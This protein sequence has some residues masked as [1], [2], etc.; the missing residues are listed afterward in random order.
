[1]CGNLYVGRSVRVVGEGRLLFTT[2]V[3]EHAAAFADSDFDGR[4]S[5]PEAVR[6]RSQFQGPP[7]GGG[8]VYFGL[9]G[10]TA[11]VHLGAGVVVVG[12]LHVAADSAVAGPL[13]LA[14]GVVKPR[15]R[16][17]RLEA[18]G[19]WSFQTERERVPGFAV[20]GGV[21]PSRLRPAGGPSAKLMEQAL[22]LS[23]PAR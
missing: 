10:A 15:D 8:A 1:V 5:S 23:A 18:E 20:T 22:Y 12:E 13:V 21:R 4:W 11:S 16:A 9:A 6:G 2:V 7:E 14:F 3:P 19:A 17:V